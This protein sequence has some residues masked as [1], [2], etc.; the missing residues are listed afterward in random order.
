MKDKRKN[1]T[2]L[3]EQIVQPTNTVTKDALELQPNPA[4]GTSHKVTMDANPAYESCK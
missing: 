2:A 3:Y 1:E 4:Y